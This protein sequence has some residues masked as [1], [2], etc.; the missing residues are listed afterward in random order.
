MANFGCGRKLCNSYYFFPCLCLIYTKHC[1]EINCGTLRGFRRCVGGG[2]NLK[3]IS[4]VVSP[5]NNGASRDC[6]VFSHEFSTSIFNCFARVQ[7]VLISLKKWIKMKL[8]RKINHKQLKSIIHKSRRKNLKPCLMFS[9][10]TFSSFPSGFGLNWLWLVLFIS[11]Q[12]HFISSTLRYWN[13]LDRGKVVENRFSKFV[14]KTRDILI[15][16]ALARL[17]IMFLF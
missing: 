16:I 7:I 15:T 5:Q 11:F 9:S 1:F 10:F 17:H 6:C 13:N 8:P 14:T 4:L 2:N 3:V 12:I